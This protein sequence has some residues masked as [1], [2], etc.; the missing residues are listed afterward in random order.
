MKRLMVIL[1][2]IGIGSSGD[3]H[4]KTSFYDCYNRL[5]YKTLIK[6]EEPWI[7]SNKVYEV[8]EG[9]EKFV[10]SNVTDEYVK[11]YEVSDSSRQKGK[12]SPFSGYSTDTC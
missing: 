10:E 6:V 4:A 8:F 9:E 12:K 5:N 3:A 1:V 2:L 7:G 11:W